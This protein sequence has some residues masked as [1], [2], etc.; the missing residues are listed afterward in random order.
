MMKRTL[1]IVLALILTIALVACGAPPEKESDPAPTPAP[2]AAATPQPTA[3][4]EPTPEP[5]P[6]PKQ[7]GVS[8]TTGLPTNRQYRP[9]TVMIENSPKARPQTGLQQADI[10]YEAMAEG[11]ITRMMCVFNDQYPVVAGP[12]RSTRMYYINLQ[13]EWDSPLIHYG[14]PRNAS[15]PSYVYGESSKHIKVRV[16]G[17]S[18]ASSKYFWRD[19][20]R[21]APNNAYTN[22]QKVADELYNYE[23]AVREPFSFSETVTYPGDTVKEVG[24]PWVSSDPTHTRFVY[25]ASSGVFTRYLGSKAFD[26]RTVSEDKNGKQ[27]TET[28]PMKV[29]NLIVQYAKTYVIP[30]DNKGRRMVDV[31]GKGECEYYIGGV[32]VKGTWE[33]ASREDSTHF[34]DAE[35]KPI[36]LRPGNTWICV[37]PTDHK[38]TVKV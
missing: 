30:N 14:G 20:S 25:D 5:T 34:Y 15:K 33:R 37:H 21:S 27:K 29:T 13:K 36:V 38:S 10:V 23:P 35:G 3:T 19:K 4:P 1:A 9:I 17:I 16:D 24:L 32:Q 7:E 18:G 6:A 8:L 28:A 26:V 22:V 11:G 12:V 2:T 31:V